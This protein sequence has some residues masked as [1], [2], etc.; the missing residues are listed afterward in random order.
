M[1]DS[2]YVPQIHTFKYFENIEN[3]FYLKSERRQLINSPYPR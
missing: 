1:R 3:T 2:F